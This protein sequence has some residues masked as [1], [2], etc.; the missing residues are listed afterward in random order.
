MVSVVQGPQVRAGET[1][2][3]MAPVAPGSAHHAG[4]AM[5]CLMLLVKARVKRV[6]AGSGC[7]CGGGGG[8]GCGGSMAGGESGR[9]P[10]EQVLKLNLMLPLVLQVQILVQGRVDQVV[11]LSGEPAAAA[12]QWAL[13]LTALLTTPKP[14]RTHR[15]VVASA[16]ARAR[17]PGS[18][19]LRIWPAQLGR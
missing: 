9:G 10:Q 7:G 12:A 5:T 16:R 3:V 19:P 15:V 13:D 14:G 17:R 4:L 8:D 6:G 2:R 11:H 18:A 1:E